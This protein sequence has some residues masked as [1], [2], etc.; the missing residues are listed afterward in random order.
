MA[1]RD[2]PLLLPDGAACTACGASVPSDR[3]RLLA[4]RDDIAFLELACPDCGS[5]AVAMLIPSPGF[6]ERA[7]LDVAT[8]ATDPRRGAAT[9]ARGAPRPISAADVEGVR[10]DLAAWH[11]DLVGWLDR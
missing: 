11:G 7:V 4:R 9:G 1:P 3:I 10:D 6:G 5:A 8:E 2:R